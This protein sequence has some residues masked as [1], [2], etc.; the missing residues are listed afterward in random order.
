MVTYSEH[1]TW[2]GAGYVLTFSLKLARSATFSLNLS[3]RVGFKHS[4]TFLLG[5]YALCAQV[6]LLSHTLLKP[7]NEALHVMAKWYC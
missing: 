4:P 5:K 1:I 2:P 7:L 6:V 3:F